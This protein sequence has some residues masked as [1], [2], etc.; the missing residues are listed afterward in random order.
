MGV[1]SDW[2]EEYERDEGLKAEGRWLVKS[3]RA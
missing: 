2:E 3:S 1:F